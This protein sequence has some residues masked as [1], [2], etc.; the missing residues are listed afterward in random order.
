MFLE[1]KPQTPV[2]KGKGRERTE[3]REEER[4]HYNASE[5]FKH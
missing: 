3:R 1:Y 2:K 5:K 4:Q